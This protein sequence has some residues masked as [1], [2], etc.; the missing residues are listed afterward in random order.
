MFLFGCP[1]SQPYGASPSIPVEQYTCWLDSQY[2]GS[3]DLVVRTLN[4]E[5]GIPR[6]SKR[7]QGIASKFK[8][9]WPYQIGIIGMQQVKKDLTNCPED[10][11]VE[12]GSHCFGKILHSEYGI[13]PVNSKSHDVLGIISS[14]D[15]RIQAN[16]AWVIGDD[17]G[18]GDDRYLMEA[19]IKNVKVGRNLKFYN[20]HLSHKK[21]KKIRSGNRL[22]QVNK[23]IEHVVSRAE[24]KDLLPIVVGDF[25]LNPSSPSLDE[26]D[27]EV[28]R[29]MS[30]KFELANEKALNCLS[31]GK[32][33]D[34]GIDLIWIG[35]KEIFP[36]SDARWKIIRY[37]T[38]A[39]RGQGVELRTSMDVNGTF[40]EKLS[41]HP[42][43]GISLR[44]EW[45]R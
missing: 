12:H 3:A 37:H 30:E 15:W 7:L 33:N 38:D 31:N 8:A 22:S 6:Y 35:K 16:T 43:P 13:A 18:T 40:I 5:R 24:K 25:N 42:S 17:G 41:D 10:R 27:K 20:T 21:G 4:T 44:F 32:P 14:G 9:D 11:S 34:I 45:G 23:L 2:R 39:D 1:L 36:Q 29:R 19:T 26:N 28:L